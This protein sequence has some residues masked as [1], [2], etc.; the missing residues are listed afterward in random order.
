MLLCAHHF[1][2]RP[3][4]SQLSFVRYP[5]SLGLKSPVLLAIVALLALG[6]TLEPSTEDTLVQAA[7]LLCFFI[8][9][10]FVL[11]R[12]FLVALLE[13]RNFVIARNIRKAAFASKP[14]GTIVAVLGM[15]HCNG[16]AELLEDSRLV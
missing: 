16:V 10:V 2:H 12:V 8:L 5:L 7:G 6:A 4:R 15:A 9:E 11:G 13:E 3:A 1:Q 14:G